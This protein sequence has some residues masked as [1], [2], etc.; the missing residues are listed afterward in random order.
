[1]KPLG[2]KLDLCDKCQAGEFGPLPEDYAGW[3]KY[4]STEA[5]VAHLKKRDDK[6]ARAAT[7]VARLRE[8][9]ERAESRAHPDTG[10]GRDLELALLHRRGVPRRL[11]EE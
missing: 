4:L 1:M 7:Q 9:V 6:A 10:N 8:Q 5:V 3:P 11:C 2:R